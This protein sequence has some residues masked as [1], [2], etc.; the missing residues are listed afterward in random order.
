MVPQI[1]LM[2]IMLM[3]IML[4]KRTMPLMA[5]NLTTGLTNW[6]MLTGKTLTGMLFH[7]E[8]LK[9]SQNTTEMSTGVKL[10]C[11]ILKI[12]FKKTWTVK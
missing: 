6:M 1:M 12:T 9:I 5:L 4:M 7:Q 3:K 11:K 8:L 2:K 10:N